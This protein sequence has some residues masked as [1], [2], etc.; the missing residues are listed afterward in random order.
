MIITFSLL[1]FALGYF[2]YKSK[3]EIILI[4]KEYLDS[5]L[6]INDE[7]DLFRELEDLFI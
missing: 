2:Y 7:D 1:F 5:K 6:D 4:E 3:D